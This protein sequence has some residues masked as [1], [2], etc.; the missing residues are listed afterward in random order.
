[1]HNFSQCS[2]SRCS[3]PTQAEAT[4]PSSITQDSVLKPREWRIGGVTCQTVAVLEGLN[5]PLAKHSGRVVV[6]CAPSYGST[7]AGSLSGVGKQGHTQI[8]CTLVLWE[9]QSCFLPAWQSMGVRVTQSKR[10]SLG[11]WAPMVVYCCN[12]PMDKTFWVPCRFTF[13]FWLLSD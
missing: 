2:E 3:F 10:K 4:D 8:K 6:L 5:C 12:C 9:G 7:E 13:C 11:G 1:M